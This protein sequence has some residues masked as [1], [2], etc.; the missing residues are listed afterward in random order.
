MEI[1]VGVKN[2]SPLPVD[3]FRVLKTLLITLGA[4]ARF[5]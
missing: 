2:F 1:P 5:E 4:L 3:F